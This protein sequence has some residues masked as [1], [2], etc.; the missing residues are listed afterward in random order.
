MFYVKY[1][2]FKKWL[3]YRNTVIVTGIAKE[4]VKN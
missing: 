3:I 2:C 4:M 1:F